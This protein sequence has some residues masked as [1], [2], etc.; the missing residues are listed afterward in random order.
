MIRLIRERIDFDGLLMTDDISMEALLGTPSERGRAALA[1]GCDVVLHCNGHFAEMEALAAD[2]PEM[3]GE[4]ARRAAAAEAARRPPAPVD[5]AA[6][7][8]ELDGLLAG[9]A[10]G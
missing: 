10:H 5:I 9:G 7:E 2:L 6:L 1:A 3:T 8:A 4:A